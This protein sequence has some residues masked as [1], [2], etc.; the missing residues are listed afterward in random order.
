M[1]SP[2]K[3]THSGRHATAHPGLLRQWGGRWGGLDVTLF[4]MHLLPPLGRR[5]R[6]WLPSD[7]GP[8]PHFLDASPLSFLSPVLDH[9]PPS[10][11]TS[12]HEQGTAAA[13]LNP[14][15]GLPLHH[16][17]PWG[18]PYGPHDSHCRSLFTQFTYGG[19]ER[20][21][22]M[23]KLTQ[24]EYGRAGIRT[25]VLCLRNPDASLG[26]CSFCQ[27]SAPLRLSP[28]FHSLLFPFLFLRQ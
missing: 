22:S 23:S 16:A 21:G 4:C 27:F 19:A 17:P 9:P 18:A 2:G 1:A 11:S 24:L 12:E 6:F 3:L 28:L 10:V 26:C 7:L 15:S 13:E 5:K 20:L 25:S 14:F 8:Q